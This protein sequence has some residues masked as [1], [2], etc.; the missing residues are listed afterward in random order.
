VVRRRAGV[1]LGGAQQAQY[2]RYAPTVTFRQASRRQQGAV[3]SKQ[4]YE[5]LWRALGNSYAADFWR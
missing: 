2:P 3:G 4:G 5:G 1:P